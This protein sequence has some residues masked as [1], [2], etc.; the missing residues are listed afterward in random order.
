MTYGLDPSQVFFV[1]LKFPCIRATRDSI[2]SLFVVTDAGGVVGTLDLDIV[3]DTEQ[4]EA[5]DRRAAGDFV[6]FQP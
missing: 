3:H 5:L 6:R 4:D 2:S 1:A